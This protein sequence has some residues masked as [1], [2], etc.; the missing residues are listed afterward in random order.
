MNYILLVF[1]CLM[2][3]LKSVYAKKSNG[4]LSAEYNVYTYNFYMFLI[5][6]VIV[7]V[8]GLVTFSGLSL[9]TVLMGLLY[10]IFLIFAQIFLIKAMD[11]G[12]VSVSSLF[13]SCGFLLPTFLGVLFYHEEVS[14]PQIIGVALILVAFV[15]TAG[16]GERPTAKWF[17]F[18]F[19]ALVCNGA[20][21]IMQK[22]FGMSA[23]RAEQSAF[24]MIAFLVGALVAFV[25]MPKTKTLLPPKKFL[26]TV[27]V[28][29]LSLGL[30]NTINVYIS[31]VLPSIIVFPSVNGG[32]IITSAVLARIL[33]GEKLSVRKKIG[34]VLGV[35]AICLIAL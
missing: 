19:S 32:G 12:G 28:S 15:V 2:N 17:L 30:V 33:I 5:S 22:V 20:V 31:G 1:S 9:A 29:G 23:H 3:G 34:I 13:Y 21:G 10:G 25:L 14:L 27:A 8:Y 16:K 24:M 6:F 4:C 11:L 7:A 26:R 35:A 18:A